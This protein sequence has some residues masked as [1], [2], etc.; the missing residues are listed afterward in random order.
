M[1]MGTDFT[2]LRN[3]NNLTTILILD[4]MN[5]NLFL[6]LLIQIS[7]IL[8]RQKPKYVCNRYI[9]EGTQEL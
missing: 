7:F 5:F 9:W 1:H 2:Y 4:N 6:V 8:C 3:T